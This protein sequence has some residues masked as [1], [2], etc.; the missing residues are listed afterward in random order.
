LAARIEAQTKNTTVQETDDPVKVDLY[1]K[2]VNNYKTNED[3]AYEVA[4]QY[5]Q[6]YVKDND[7]YSR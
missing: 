4:K 6:K 3:A 2:F 5:L 7:Q 1:T